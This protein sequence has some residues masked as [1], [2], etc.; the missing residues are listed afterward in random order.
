LKINII[1]YIEVVHVA[2]DQQE[3]EMTNSSH[4]KKN[5]GDAQN[6]K[7]NQNLVNARRNVK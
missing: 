4:W 3:N 6:E 7:E 5:K 2:A 1:S